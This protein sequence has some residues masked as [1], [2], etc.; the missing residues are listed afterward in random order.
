[1][2]KSISILL[3]STS[4]FATDYSSM[5]IDELANLRGN[6]ATEDRDAF[7]SA[8]Q[9]KTQYLTPEEQMAYKKGSGSANSNATQTQQRLKD[10]S[11][12]GN[13]YKGS[14]GHGGSR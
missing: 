4:I 12:S 3:L 8:W 13:M 10:G 11:G 14:H 1:M 9:D 7:R 6:I 5:S 2:K